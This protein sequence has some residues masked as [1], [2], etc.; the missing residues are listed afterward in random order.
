MLLTFIANLNNQF[1]LLFTYSR[2]QPDFGLVALNRKSTSNLVE[3][4]DRDT[5]VSCKPPYLMLRIKKD[6]LP[7]KH[8]FT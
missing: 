7:S 4:F 1:F 2:V 3:H 5:Q 8:Y 6:G